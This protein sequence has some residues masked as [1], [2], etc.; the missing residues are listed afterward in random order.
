MPELGSGVC[1][2]LLDCVMASG[3]TAHLAFTPVAGALVERA[4]VHAHGDTWYLHLPS[5]GIDAGG[6][7]RHVQAGEVVEDVS[8]PELSGTDERF[9]LEGFYGE[10]ASFFDDIRAGRRPVDDL[11]ST[12][13]SVAAAQCIRERRAE[14][15]AT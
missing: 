15:G 9:V 7:L 13:Q 12:R 8:G 3:A 2:I 11:R 6:R 10:N 14:Y 5:G 1:N 4:A